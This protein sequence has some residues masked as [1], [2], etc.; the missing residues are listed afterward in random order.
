MFPRFVCRRGCNAVAQAQEQRTGE[1][2]Q[3]AIDRGC[4]IGEVERRAD[5]EGRHAG[6]A[7]RAGNGDAVD[8]GLQNSGASTEHVGHFGRR[9]VLA[10]PAEGVADAVDE[11]EKSVVV[12]AH[13]VA[14]AKPGIALDE[15]V[16]QDLAFGLLAAGIAFESRRGAG[17]VTESAD[18]LAGLVRRAAHAE[19]AVVA[20]R[21]F[22]RHIE[23]DD[24][25]G[26]PVP[27]E[28]RDPAD[29]AGFAFEIDQRKAA[30]AG[31]I[32]FQDLRNGEALL[33]C[34][35]NLGAQSV[36]AADPQAMPSLGGRRRLVEE[37]TTEL[38]D[39]LKQRA[40]E[41]DDVVPELARGKP[42]PQHHR[43]ATC[44]QRA[45]R[46]DAADA[47]V[48]RQAIVHAIVRLHVHQAG[49]PEAPG[50]DPTMADIGRLGQPGGAR[51]VDAECAIGDIDGAPFRCR[52]WRSAELR[53]RGVDP[54]SVCCR[55]AMDPEQKRELAARPARLRR[56]I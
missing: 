8:D 27:Q 42:R 10:L 33:E 38:T 44:Q 46:H 54:R 40:I 18:R 11:V 20:Q 39:I 52:E 37:I 36:A 17:V 32:E 41:A 47:V 2:R 23:A 14:G 56:R 43:S 30:L 34:G 9:H 53:D 21:R 29:R 25:R 51:G 16:S 3:A 12:A 22:A 31:G 13:Q 48:H 4:E 28:G 50:Q 19:A 45:D 5:H 15:D 6:S 26:K 7:F 35:P 24:L 55:A 1:A 49:E